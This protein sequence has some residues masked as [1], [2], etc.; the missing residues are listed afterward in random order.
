[1]Y[2]K[3]QSILLIGQS[4]MV[5]VGVLNS[6]DPIDDDRLFMMRGDE[7]IKMKEPLHTN[8]GRAGIGLGASFGKAFVDTFGCKVGLIPAAKGSTRLCDWVVGGDLYNEA[9]RLAKLALET[10]DMAAILWHQGEGNQHTLDY[11]AQLKVIFDAMI[12]DIG[13]D[14]EKIV[15]IT[16]ELFGGRSDEIHKPQLIEL[17]KSYKNYGIAHS[18]GLGAHDVTTHFDGPSLRVFGYRYFA[19]FYRITTGGVF[20]F[21]DNPKTYWS[22]QFKNEEYTYVP[23]DDMLTGKIGTGYC[24]NA[25]IEVTKHRGEISAIAENG[26]KFLSV[27]NVLSTPTYIKVLNSEGLG[28]TVAAE[29]QI[30]LGENHNLGAYILTMLNEGSEVT[31]ENLYVRENGWLAVVKADG[32]MTDVIQL[33]ETDWVSL[34]VVLDTERNLKEIYVNDE[35]VLRG[36][37]ISNEVNPAELLID[38]TALVSYEASESVGCVHIDEY[39]FHPYFDNLQPEE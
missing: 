4:N 39:R 26:G 34:R 2:D 9:V 1:M 32:S 35:L 37:K 19:E 38:R 31:Y 10:T 29:M 15:I 30:R 17:G 6:V 22:S 8:T 14:P 36:V 28:V 24:G 3:M 7:W 18:R 5:G 27:S 33:N 25:E 11:A 23:F 12:A 16:G 20:E 21:D 13:L